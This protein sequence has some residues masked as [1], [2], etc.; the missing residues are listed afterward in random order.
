MGTLA[1][2]RHRD[3]LGDGLAAAH[4][5]RPGE[6]REVAG[7]E[8]R[9]GA[10]QDA[11]PHVAR[12]GGAAV[13]EADGEV[14]DVAAT[15]GDGPGDRGGDE[16]DALHEGRR[17]RADVVHLGGFRHHVGRVDLDQHVVLTG[18]GRDGGGRAGRHGDDRQAAVERHAAVHTRQ[19]LGPALRHL[20]VRPAVG[21][22]Q[23]ELL[24]AREERAPHEV[25]RLRC[26]RS[27][28]GSS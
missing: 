1:R 4:H 3:G 20:D 23:V 27:S 14:L 26:D 10:Q 15:R 25:G 21:G 7:V 19:A 16:V 2:D 12:R 9:I 22:R 28:A 8:Q 18:G 13:E 24:I 17:G 5:A 11:E 6:D